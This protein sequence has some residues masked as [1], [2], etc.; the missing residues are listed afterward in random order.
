MHPE[1]GI[2]LQNSPFDQFRPQLT[3]PTDYTQTQ[4]VGAAMR[5]AGVEVFEYES[6]RAADNGIGVGVFSIKA[7][8]Q[9]A[10]KNQSQWFCDTNAD[11]VTFK[12]ME[13][14]GQTSVI[15]F[16]NQLFL[17]S[18]QLPMPSAEHTGG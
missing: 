17:I 1:N 12:R 10:P 16:E 5:G 3:S 4:K 11:S 9:N 6:V 2:K 8:V 15:S 7:F 13:R 18:G 14:L